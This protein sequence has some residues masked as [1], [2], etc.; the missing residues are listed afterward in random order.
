MS[1][2][3]ASF[4]TL[5]VLSER[6]RFVIVDEETGVVQMYEVRGLMVISVVADRYAAQHE[7]PADE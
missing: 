6:Q 2:P 3:H 7:A 4:P 1:S 5:P